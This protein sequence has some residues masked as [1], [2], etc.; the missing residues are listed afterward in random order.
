M[1]VVDDFPVIQGPRVWVEEI[2]QRRR[3]SADHGRDDARDR[4]K[5]GIGIP[6]HSGLDERA[7][8]GSLRTHGAYGGGADLVEPLTPIH[9]FRLRAPP[10][11]PPPAARKARSITRRQSAR[12]SRLGRAG[13]RGW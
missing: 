13:S 6:H 11:S 5:K 12:R 10:A 9:L 3:L 4:Q 7:R 8:L 2:G 1:G